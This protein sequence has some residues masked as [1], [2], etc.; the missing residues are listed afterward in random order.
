MF[1]DMVGYTAAAQVDERATLALRNEQEAIVRPML[2]K[3]QGR[4]VKS[5]G[6]GLLVEF[7]SSLKATECAIS[8][9]RKL[10]ERSERTTA[11]PINLRIGIHLG[12]VEQQGADIFGD[13]VNIASRIQPVAEPGGI[14]VS[15]AV[16]EQVWNKISDKLE[17]LPP[18]A[19]NGLRV[20]MDL[21]RVILPWTD[22]ASRSATP[23]P[24]GIAVLPFTNISPD[25]KDEYFADGLTEEL[26]SVLSRLR[27]LRIIARTS[28]TPYKSTSKGVSQIGAELGVSSILEGSVRKSGSRLR[29]T[30]QLID[31]GSQGHVWA[32]TYDRELDDIFAV[33]TDI[34]MQVMDALKLE[35][36][37]I[38]RTRLHARRPARK[39]S[40]LAYLKGRTL[41]HDRS[42]A[43][44]KA[45]EEQFEIAIRLDPENASAYSG[46]SD[47]LY[48]LVTYGY[49][50]PNR[51]EDIALGRTYAA[52]AVELDADLAEAHASLGSVYW[53]DF[54]HADAERE[55]LL[56]LSLNP[57]YPQAHTWYALLLEELGRPEEAL[58][59][60]ALAEQADPL[61]LPLLVSTAQ[62]L[63]WLGRLDEAQTRIEKL[64]NAK[65]TLWA[66]RTQM[67]EYY[68]ARSDPE[69]ALKVLDQTKEARP[70]DPRLLASYADYYARTGQTNRAIELLREFE[71]QT[72]GLPYREVTLADVYTSLGK[73]D[74]V[75][76]WLEKALEAHWLDVRNWRLNPNAA[77]VRADPRFQA[78]LKRMK[79]A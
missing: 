75:F 50:G 41:A 79:L 22:E 2:T 1:T 18:T 5:T 76:R 47:T 9:Q 63:R 77:R 68:M 12:D 26:I 36:A 39:D 65:T 24:T 17:K 51:A 20:Q 37:G 73:L 52:R 16:H 62:L 15:N 33:Q 32:H 54:R 19:L 13:A 53:Y 34:A 23:G 21:Y 3:H 6:D 31:V 25:P 4:V 56:A 64:W 35:L 74:E 66:G 59:E 29:I 70:G 8:I 67:F 46:L 55:F 38:E 7:D 48:H 61:S 78:L 42:E 10:H 44:L 60:F 72:E 58:Q 49:T 69:R 71:T 40:Y 11:T 43:G 14:C 57:S 30:V 45:A 28:I 27:D